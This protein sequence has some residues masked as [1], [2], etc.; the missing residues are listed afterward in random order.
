MPALQAC[1]A[2]K[3]ELRCVA[4]LIVQ[5]PGSSPDLVMVQDC[6]EQYALATSDERLRAFLADQPQYFALIFWIAEVPPFAL[7]RSGS[8]VKDVTLRI[9]REVVLC[10]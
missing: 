1:H 8:K 10:W 6:T 7:L 3:G 9:P 4:T 5:E 2:R